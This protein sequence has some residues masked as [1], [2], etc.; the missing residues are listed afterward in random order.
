MD[1]LRHRPPAEWVALGGTAAPRDRE[2]SHASAVWF[3]SPGQVGIQ[4]EEVPAPGPD[5]VRIRAIASAISHGTELLVYRGQ[6]T[7]D[8]ALDLPT[9]QGSFG[10]PIKY[11]YASVG[12][13]LEA[14]A[15]VRNPRVGDV[16]FTLHPHQTEYVVPARLVMALPPDLRPEIGV[17]TASLETALNVVLDAHPRLGER[18]V[19]FGQGVVG[20]LVTQL[21]RRAG[22]E[23]IVAVDPIERRRELAR[24]VGA[25]HALGPDE[26][27]VEMVRH[28]TGGVGADLAIEV[29]GNPEALNQAIAAV[30]IQGT[31]VSASWYGT[32]PAALQLGGAFHRGRVRLISSQVGSIDPALQPRW[33]IARRLALVR[34][35]LPRLHLDSLI[36]H[37]LPFA[38]AATAYRLI[39]RHPEESIQIILTYGNDR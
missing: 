3:T 1:S 29:S 37:R 14:G 2:A 34:D 8:L 15:A 18:L 19:I 31:V 4:M 26:D 30:A 6:V 13:V 24:R 25:D 38:D 12:Q 32:K 33:S 28:L 39:D 36:T 16:V 9:L 23:L 35:L 17:F 20:L 22:A 21:A 5:E 27:L 10:F 11:G 7:A